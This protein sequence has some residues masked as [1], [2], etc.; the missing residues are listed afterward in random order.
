[1]LQALMAADGA[2]SAPR[3]CSTSVWDANVDP[4]T[5]IVRM[6]VMKLRRKLGEP[7]RDRDRAGR[8]VPH[9]SAVRLRLTLFYAG[10]LAAASGLLLGA[11][12]V[13]VRAHLDAH[14]GRRRWPARPCRRSPRST[15]SRW[16]ASSC[17]RRAAAGS[18]P[19]EVLAPLARAIDA[20]RRFVANASH[21][22]RTP[23]TRSASAAEV[24]L[25]DP[26]P[27]VEGLRAVLRETV[28]APRRPTGS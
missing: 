18:S 7:A 19:G 17:S 10:L 12:Y 22:L 21:E 24:A 6:T 9:V 8:R 14:A 23:M 2:S 27:T 26:A 20:Q 15:S 1:M 28:A 4:F 3:S 25:D 16:S 11:S 13:L 5:N